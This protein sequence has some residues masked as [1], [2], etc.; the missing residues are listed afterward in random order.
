V[1]SCVFCQV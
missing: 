1:G